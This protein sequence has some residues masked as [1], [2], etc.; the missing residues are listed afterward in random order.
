MDDAPS[1]VPL[2]T[3]RGT[4]ETFEGL[5]VVDRRR[6]TGPQDRTHG[7]G[8]SQGA[9]G[10]RSHV[11]P[12]SLRPGQQCAIPQAVDGNRTFPP[13]RVPCGLRR[14]R[15]YGCG[16]IRGTRRA[17]RGIYR[18]ALLI[19]NLLL[20]IPYSLFDRVDPR[21]VHLLPNSPT[22]CCLDSRPRP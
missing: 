10:C 11:S 21:Q 4:S 5:I 18:Q 20:L 2:I 17:R 19:C 14:Y 1:K 22:L 6:Q 13:G 8:S 15:A 9:R 7:A 3:P 12:S 16:E